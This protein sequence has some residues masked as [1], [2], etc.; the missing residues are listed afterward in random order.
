MLFRPEA[1]VYN[2]AVQRFSTAAQEIAN[3]VIKK[4]K[5]GIQPML[6]VITSYRMFADDIVCMSGTLPELQNQLF[7][8]KED[9][10]I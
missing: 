6:D 10:L 9:E 2:Y 4:G 3:E 1:R 8:P 5:H 7:C